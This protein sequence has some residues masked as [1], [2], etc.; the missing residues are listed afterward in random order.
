MNQRAI[1]LIIAV[2]GAV[3]AWYGWQEHQSVGSQ[4]SEMMT[5]SPTDR[6]LWMLIGGGVLV[7]VGL[8]MAG[9]VL[10]GGRRR[11]RR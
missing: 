7:V 9:G 1:G 8:V 10:G 5:G 6:S 3:L 2:V 4:L 11:S